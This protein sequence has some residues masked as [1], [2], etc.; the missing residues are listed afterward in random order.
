MKPMAKRILITKIVAET[1]ERLARNR[2]FHRAFIRAGT[3]LPSDGSADC[4]V[5]L[6][7]VEF[8]YKDV[9]TPAASKLVERI[10]K[11]EQQR[12]RL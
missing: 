8:E 4:E 6:Q 11:F 7:G 9:T 1:H 3:F 12:K 2:I 10:L 5:N